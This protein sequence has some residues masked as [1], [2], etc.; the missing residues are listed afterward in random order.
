MSTWLWTLTQLT[1][2]SFCLYLAQLSGSL[3]CHSYFTHRT[4]AMGY[5]SDPSESK[6]DHHYLLLDYIDSGKDRMLSDTLT[7]FRET[8]PVRLQNLLRGISR[9]MTSLASKAQPCIG[10]LRFNDDG[11]TTPTNHPLLCANS[12]LESEGAPRTVDKTYT[13]TGT[14]MDDMLR[15]R[16]RALSA[17]PNAVNDEEDCHPQML[18][19]MLCR[20]LK[21]HFVDQHSEGPFVLQYTDYHASNVFVDDERNIVALINLDFVCAL[22]PNMMTVPTDSQWTQSLS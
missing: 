6:F 2:E 8:D 21:S 17:L 7:D 16:D 14:F 19:M 12:L 13:T 3:T 10:L 9:I 1:G 22:P 5:D 18:H 11:S 15:F 20:R 4:N